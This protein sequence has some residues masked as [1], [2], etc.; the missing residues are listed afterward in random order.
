MPK[1]KKKNPKR[2]KNSINKTI[3]NAAKDA[4]RQ[5]PLYTTGDYANWHNH[6]KNIMEL[7]QKNI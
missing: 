6:H 5:E 1:S 7:P 3:T 2:K 4:E